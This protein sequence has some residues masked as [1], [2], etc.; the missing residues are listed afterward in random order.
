MFR[1]FL[2]T[3]IKG[4][5]DGGLGVDGGGVEE[6]DR[7]MSLLNEEGDFGAAEDDGLSALSG[8]GLDDLEVA[9]SGC[10]VQFS[11][12]E[13]GVDN[14][15][16]VLAFGGGGGDDVDAVFGSEAAFVEGVFHGEFG[17]EEADGGDVL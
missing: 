10:G 14:L 9:G 17:A 6:G 8:E 15:V 3:T 4:V 11:E 13:F 16:D 1:F 5:G 12:A 7:S 2:C